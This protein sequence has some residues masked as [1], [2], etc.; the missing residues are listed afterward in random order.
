MNPKSLENKREKKE[1]DHFRVASVLPTLILFE[2]I[3]PAE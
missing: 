2:A 1:H 3:Y